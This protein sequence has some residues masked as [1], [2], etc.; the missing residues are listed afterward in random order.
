M[1]NRNNTQQ[2]NTRNYAKRHTYYIIHRLT[3]V[4]FVRPVPAVVP[5]VALIHGRLSTPARVATLDLIRVTCYTHA[6]QS[7]AY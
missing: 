5:S 1:D 2:K 4:D 3:A 7:Y 6:R